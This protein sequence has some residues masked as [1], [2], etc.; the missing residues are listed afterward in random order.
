MQA[1]ITIKYTYDTERHPFPI[2]HT[3]DLKDWDKKNERVNFNVPGSTEINAKIKE[4]LSA[5]GLLSNQ[6]YEDGKAPTV[7]VMKQAYQEYL[8]QVSEDQ[9]K[10]FN[11]VKQDAYV[12]AKNFDNK[13][14]EALKTQ[15]E[16]EKLEAKLEKKVE[17]M[18]RLEDQ[19][20]EK[21]EAVEEFGKNKPAFNFRNFNSSLEIAKKI[22]AFTQAPSL[23]SEGTRKEFIEYL[24][25]CILKKTKVGLNATKE[26]LRQ[27]PK[28]TT[29]TNK[30][31]RSWAKTLEEFTTSKQV[32]KA[33]LQISVVNFSPEFY[34]VY[35]YFLQEPI[36]QG[37]H[38]L[39]DNTFGAH[40]K[41]L[42]GFCRW[43]E[44]DEKVKHLDHGSTGT[45]CLKYLRKK[46]RL[47]N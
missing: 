16:I 5:L 23:A 32:R 37:G 22:Q 25:K 2:G 13:L 7:A 20:L 39:Y 1:S 45:N 24:N 33:A 30:G 28:A 47:L 6:L 9:E 12:L 35:A 19:V 42:R 10:Q 3:I 27:H 43:M 17:V 14:F 18:V 36:A 41:K 8:K 15:K 40:V 29:G 34:D 31:L 38:D 26:E 21:G 44:L 46:K 4:S 11:G